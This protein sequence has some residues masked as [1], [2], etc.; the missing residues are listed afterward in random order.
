MTSAPD[1]N[2]RQLFQTGMQMLIVFAQGLVVAL[3]AIGTFPT[4]E[5]LYLAVL[6]SA[7]S[8]IVVAAAFFGVSKVR[9]GGIANE[10][11]AVRALNTDPST[12]ELLPGTT[13]ADLAKPLPP[14]VH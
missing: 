3:Y 9:I 11:V 6:G 8:A 12:G 10:E 13:A 7:G 2:K 5:Q 14:S 4:P 1:N